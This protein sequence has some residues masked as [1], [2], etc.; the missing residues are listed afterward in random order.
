[1][2]DPSIRSSM[3]YTDA[4]IRGLQAALSGKT[5]KVALDGVAA[6]WDQITQQVGVDKQR[7]A[8]RD[9]ASKPAAYP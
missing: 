8:Y 5:P 3:R 2:I 7:E 9:W 6:E 1:M 4:L